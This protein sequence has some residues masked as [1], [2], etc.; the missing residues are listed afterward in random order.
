[1]T[2]PHECTEII[3]LPSP[4]WFAIARQFDVANQ[5]IFVHFG[6]TIMQGPYT[7]AIIYK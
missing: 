5:H 3:L 2:V 6:G 4:N 1:M 7:N